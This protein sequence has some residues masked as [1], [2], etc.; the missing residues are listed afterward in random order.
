MLPLWPALC[1]AIGAL[2]GGTAVAMAAIAAHALPQRLDAKALESIHSA[3]QMQGW[4]AL[5]LLFTALWIV[6]AGPLPGTIASLAGA[7]FILGTL[8][9]SGS[10]YLGHLAGLHPGPT[11]PTG[12]ILLMLGWLLL[13]ASALA[14]TR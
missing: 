9:F 3:I 13:A 12:G 8:L 10:I 2:L 4:H 11:A 5:V 1:M 14:A 6:R 7:A